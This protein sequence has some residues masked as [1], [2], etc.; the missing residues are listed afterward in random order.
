MNE[1]KAEINRLKQI[2]PGIDCS[3]KTVNGVRLPVKIYVP[4]DN[5]NK[6]TLLIH[7]NKQ[8]YL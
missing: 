8:K 4:V 2:K 3:Y 6:Q 5:K 7:L 1:L